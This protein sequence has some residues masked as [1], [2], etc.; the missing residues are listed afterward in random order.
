VEE[1]KRHM[2]AIADAVHAALL[3][4]Q[5]VSD[6]YTARGTHEGC[7]ECCGRFLPLFAHEA[8]ALRYAA[9][10]LEIPPEP[11]NAVDMRCPLLGADNRCMAY[12]ARPTV[13]RVYD[14]AKHAADPL[15]MMR[16]AERGGMRPGMEIYDMREVIA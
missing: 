11:P 15:A 2:E 14:C 16:D 9:R 4:T 7:G 13:C 10:N 3:E 8:V 1:G 5:R 12:D 6:L